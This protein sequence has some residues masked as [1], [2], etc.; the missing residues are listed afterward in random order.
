MLPLK[1]LGKDLFQAPLLSCGC[2]L[3]F[4]SVTHLD[5]TFCM[6][7]SVCVGVCV[8]LSVCPDFP[9][10]EDMSDFSLG[11]HPSPIYLILI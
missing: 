4:D 9:F 1:A 6:G 3:A 5:M 7:V 10:Y 2:S 8:C 11:A